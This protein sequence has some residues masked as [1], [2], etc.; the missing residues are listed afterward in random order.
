MTSA[1][2]GAKTRVSSGPAISLKSWIVLAVFVCSLAATLVIVNPSLEPIGGQGR[3]LI[4]LAVSKRRA[5]RALHSFCRSPS[6]HVYLW[7]NSR[8]HDFALRSRRPPWGWRASP[9]LTRTRL[10]KSTRNSSSCR[11]PSRRRQ[12]S[13]GL[14][15]PSHRDHGCNSRASVPLAS[16]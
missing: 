15:N 11:R 7:F 12:Y 4:G 8:T 10:P 3:G 9:S 2:S 16:S 6:C 14:T 1:E 13:S 5:L